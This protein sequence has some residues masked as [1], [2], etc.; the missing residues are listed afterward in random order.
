MVQCPAR[1]GLR[2]DLVCDSTDPDRLKTLCLEH[3]ASC[4]QKR[5]RLSSKSGAL[6]EKPYDVALCGLVVVFPR[7]PA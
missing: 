5:C 1:A 6:V 4:G 3:S 7:F 2:F